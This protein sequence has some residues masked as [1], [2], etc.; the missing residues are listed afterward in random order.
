MKLP[1]FSTIGS[2]AGLMFTNRALTLE[3]D[4]SS[5]HHHHHA[6]TPGSGCALDVCLGAHPKAANVPVPPERFLLY[7]LYDLAV[8]V[9]YRPL[10]LFAFVAVLCFL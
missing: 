4:D 6:F 7:F 9:S 10:G 2:L 5:E 3:E 8:Q 1:P